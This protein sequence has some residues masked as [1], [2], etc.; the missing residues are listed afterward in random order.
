MSYPLTQQANSWI[1]YV[2][3]YIAIMGIYYSDV[4]NVRLLHS[5]TV[6]RY[7]CS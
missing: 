5:N 2:I 3:C 7:Q 6:L 1:G 4:W